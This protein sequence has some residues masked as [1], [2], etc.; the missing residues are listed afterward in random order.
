VRFDAGGSTAPDTTITAYR[1]SFGDGHT[2]TGS[3]ATHRYATQRTYTVTL[4]V[5]DNLG[6]TATAGHALAVRPALHGRLR[7]PKHQTLPAVLQ[8]GLVV[9]LSTTERTRARFR[10]TTRIKAN[11]H[12]TATVVTLMRAR[13]RVVRRGAHRI[14]LKLGAAGTRRLR[15][16]PTMLL[17]V[18]V[19]LTD[20]YGRKLKLSAHTRLTS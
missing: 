14:T 2:G 13:P 4:T 12:R 8:H 15:G 6:Q 1:W 9:K 19:T 17:A 11:P 7:I 16:D 5:T 3:V 10:I 18:Q 20:V